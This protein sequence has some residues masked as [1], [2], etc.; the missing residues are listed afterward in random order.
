[1]EAA[2]PF[3]TNRLSK[4]VPTL[5]VI[6]VAKMAIAVFGW[7]T[8]KLLITSESQLTLRINSGYP[9]KSYILDQVIKV[10]VYLA[11][12]VIY[13]IKCI[14]YQYRN[15]AVTKQLFAVQGNEKMYLIYFSLIFVSEILQEK[16]LS[17]IWR[18]I[19]ISSFPAN[20][21]CYQL[22]HRLF[23]LSSLMSFTEFERYFRLNY[24]STFAI[25]F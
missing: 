11:D 23:P 5:L 13:L 17:I 15:I 16:N 21:I 24:F 22:L 7:A 25:Y 12:V 18:S 4:M 10:I 9:I 3:R 20:R 6:Y 14:L 1:M 2:A 19:Q 8:L